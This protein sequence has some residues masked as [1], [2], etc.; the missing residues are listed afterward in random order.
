M[1]RSPKRCKESKTVTT[2]HGL[3][4]A[5]RAWV[6]WGARASA[7]VLAGGCFRFLALTLIRNRRL[8]TVECRTVPNHRKEAHDRQPSAAGIGPRLKAPGELVSVEPRIHH[9]SRDGGR[10]RSDRVASL[11]SKSTLPRP[12]RFTRASPNDLK[13]RNAKNRH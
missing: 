5:A 11:F 10:T 3:A 8:A 13:S 12:Q 2:K 7:E 1:P 6:E 9:D 4:M